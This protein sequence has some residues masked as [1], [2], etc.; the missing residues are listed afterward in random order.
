MEMKENKIINLE[1]EIR[2]REAAK[3]TFLVKFIVDKASSYVEPSRK[4]V[5]KGQ[6]IGFSWKKYEMNLHLMFGPFSM[7]MGHP[8]LEKNYAKNILGISYSQFR[9][10]KY[11]KEFK[12][13]FTDHCWEYADV[14]IEHVKEKL[15]AWDK[16]LDHEINNNPPQDFRNYKIALDWPEFEHSKWY[17]PELQNAIIMGI[18]GLYAQSHP[19]AL[20]LRWGLCHFRKALNF[21][22]QGE[23][24][25]AL[26]HMRDLIKTEISERIEG[27]LLQENMDELGQKKVLILL[28]FMEG[29]T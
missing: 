26:T 11:Q 18:A 16:A 1:D 5:P 28:K 23:G 4:N 24:A 12:R 10:W 22:N 7:N 27:F 14:V 29:L 13:A 20:S 6:K 2:K 21:S 9:T 25:M 19:Q 17:D 8:L 15:K 3:N